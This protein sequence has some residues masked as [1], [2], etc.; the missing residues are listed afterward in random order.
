MLE[1]LEK[2]KKCVILKLMKKIIISI[3]LILVAFSVCFFVPK[4]NSVN[5]E[6]TI[7][8]AEENSIKVF[9]GTNNVSLVGKEGD[10]KLSLFEELIQCETSNEPVMFYR[11]GTLYK[12]QYVIQKATTDH[13]SG[14]DVVSTGKATIEIPS[15][16]QYYLNS[17]KKV[18]VSASVGH[19]GLSNNMRDQVSFALTVDEN[20]EEKQSTKYWN[21]SSYEYIP[22]WIDFSKQEITKNSTIIF[23][24]KSGERYGENTSKGFYIFNPTITF[25]VENFQSTEDEITIEEI[26]I[27]NK[28]YDGTTKAE[29]DHVVLSGISFNEN[30]SISGLSV[31]FNSSLVGATPII[32][33]T[34]VISGTEKTLN[35]DYSSAK[36]T[37]TILKRDVV[38]KASQTSKEYISKDE[39]KIEYET[40]N[41][42]DGES[43]EGELSREE[44]GSDFS[45]GKYRIVLGTLNNPNYNIIFHSNVYEIIKTEIILESIE[46][47]KDYDGTNVVE[48]DEIEVN[49]GIDTNKDG[50]VDV[51]FNLDQNGFLKD[52]QENQTKYLE[53]ESLHFEYTYFFNEIN[54]GEYPISV[55]VP[56]EL[57][58][59]SANSFYLNTRNYTTKATINQIELTIKVDNK[60]K[61][62]GDVDPELTYSITEGSLV[63]TE[64]LK[65]NI[66]REQGENVGEYEINIGT[67]K[68][69]NPNYQI[70]IVNGVLTIQKREIE[71]EIFDAEKEYGEADPTFEFNITKGNLIGNDRLNIEIV[72]NSNEE[73]GEY[74]LT[75]KTTNEGEIVCNSNYLIVA[76]EKGVFK[77]NKNLLTITIEINKKV[78][79]GTNNFSFSCCF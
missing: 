45:A 23:E 33:G 52:K 76:Y 6:A 61:I 16:I 49:I 48:N 47:N 50:E 15:S 4:T 35:Q 13:F 46:I 32:S 34:P 19:L 66:E 9:S 58:G 37:G 79:D 44:A 54:A 25:T 10:G 36:T 57:T 65:G 64:T 56:R 31:E 78:Y 27:K 51:Y 39:T 75:L 42:L 11:N 1:K 26:V 59:T 68:A 69:S 24:F 8:T 17:G 38:V 12:N 14:D 3:C 63:G 71:L 73:I 22:N 7:E 74:E 72:S 30:L 2:N 21:Q 41:I 28:G 62:Y 40:F 20:V 60:T 29:I 5:A 70:S 18:F 55:T 67:L 53:S 43:L 77:I